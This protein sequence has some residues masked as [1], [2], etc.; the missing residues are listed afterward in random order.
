MVA[1]LIISL[2]PSA[3]ITCMLHHAQLTLMILFYVCVCVCVCMCVSLCVFAHMPCCGTFSVWRSK[4][5]CGRRISQPL[6]PRVG[7]GGGGVEPYS[8][9]LVASAFKE[10]SP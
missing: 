10:P 3:G 5:P 2:P 8:L 4:G 7:G 9:G 1:E 6:D